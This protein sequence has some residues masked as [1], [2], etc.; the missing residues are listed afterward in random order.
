MSY[1]ETQTQQIFQVLQMLS[2][3]FLGGFQ[4]ECDTLIKWM[5]KARSCRLYINCDKR[6]HC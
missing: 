2:F 3:V 6:I 5:A 4:D 1:L